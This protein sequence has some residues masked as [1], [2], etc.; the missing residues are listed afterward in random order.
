LAV[1]LYRDDDTE[2]SSGAVVRFSRLAT[3]AVLVIGAT[4]LVLGWQQILT[5]AAL[6]STAYGWTLIAKVSVVAVVVLI[7]AYNRT[8]LVPAVRSARDDRRARAALRW[9]VAVEAGALVVAVG[10]TAGL[11]NTTPGRNS[12]TT[13]FSATAPIGD[14]TVNLVVDPPKAGATTID[15]FFLDDR[16]EPTALPDGSE[17]TLDLSLP[18]AQIGPI[19]RVPL[20]A[21]PGHYQLEGADL[22]VPGTW[23]VQVS[24]RVS[25]FDLDSADF[26]VPVRP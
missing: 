3:V 26:E 23:E 19:E 12:V 7:G 14:A 8:R 11:V 1:S 24:A 18:A 15:V 17:V 16:G 13:P 22:S 9:T 5:R 21:G 10:L 25:R 4:G 20:V 2:G 6:T